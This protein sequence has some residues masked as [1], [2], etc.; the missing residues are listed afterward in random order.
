RNIY[1]RIDAL[2][3]ARGDSPEIERLGREV[4][5]ISSALAASESDTAEILA[6]IDALQAR[7][8]QTPAPG[9]TSQELGFSIDALRDAIVS[10]IEP[11]FE[12]LAKTQPDGNIESQLRH[13]VQ[14]VDRTSAQL[15][16]LA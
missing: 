9:D 16:T 14:T 13:I 8:A 6:R 1:E 10:A 12:A 3:M 4:G 11:R 7:I 5:A 2:E 15:Q